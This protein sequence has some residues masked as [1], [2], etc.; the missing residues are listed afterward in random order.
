[1]VRSVVTG[2]AGFVGSHIVDHLLSWGE[3]VI[4][5]DDFSTGHP[6]N[7]SQWAAHPNLEVRHHCITER[8]ALEPAV[9][10]CDRVFHLAAGVGVRLVS[11]QP[12]RVIDTNLSGTMAVLRACAEHGRP[13]LLASTSEVYGKTCAPML[14]EDDDLILGP[15]TSPRW[16]YACSKAAGEFLARAYQAEHDLPVVTV[17]LFNTAGPRQTGRY[18]MVIP[19]FVSQALCGQP[20][21]VY[22]DGSQTRCFCDVRDVAAALVQLIE[23]PAARGQVVNLGGDQPVPI[24]TLAEQIKALTESSSEIIQVPFESAYSSGME[25]TQDRRPDL[26]KA[27]QLIGFQPTRSLERILK[28]VIADQGRQ[29]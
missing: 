17:R 27:R 7:L 9:A 16:S 15:S 5:I 12:V 28:D 29:A 24:Q 22:G 23:E 18:G 8:A 2:G 3:Q 10:G 21:T 20:I 19:R 11:E 13:V 1:M 26:S 6:D 14:K 25:D 4:A